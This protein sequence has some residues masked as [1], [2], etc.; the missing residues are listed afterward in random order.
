[1]NITS[2]YANKLLKKL[3]EDKEFWL[4]KESE[5]Y[6]Y[7]AS[8]DEDPVIPDYD[9]LEVAGHISEIDDKILK[10][11]HAL[12]IANTT[13]TITYDDITLT[14]DAALVKMS[15]LNNRKTVLDRMRKQQP[16]TRISSGYLAA[17]KSAP[18]YQ[19]INY[20]LELVQQEYDRVDS[21]IS[22]LQLALD[23]HNQTREFEVEL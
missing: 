10:I 6:V 15:Q 8:A 5:G 20:D 23:R 18:E 4:A 19:Y 1:M 21:E 14:I 16:K 11:K 7:V 12:N 22:S 9:Y 3:N 2:A 13:G 17:R